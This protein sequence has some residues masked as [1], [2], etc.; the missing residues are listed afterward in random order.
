MVV[1]GS[2]SVSDG[3]KAL[4]PSLRIWAKDQKDLLLTERTMMVTIRKAIAVG[5]RLLSNAGTNGIRRIERVERGN[6]ELYDRRASI[7]R[8]GDFM[9]LAT[10]SPDDCAQVKAIL[11]THAELQ[12]RNLLNAEG[13]LAR[14]KRDEPDSE[15][16]G[17]LEQDNIELVAD[18]ENLKR[19][20]NLF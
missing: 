17:D 16:I 15:L 8:N 6:R 18:T 2:K 20:A 19:L 9:T 10:L 11:L 14:L 3:A 13:V 7:D 4:E 5:L 12:D 1:E